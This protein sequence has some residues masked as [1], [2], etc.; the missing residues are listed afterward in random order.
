[1]KS[2]LISIKMSFGFGHPLQP[3]AIIILISFLGA[4]QNNF[5]EF[6]DQLSIEFLGNATEEF[7]KIVTTNFPEIPKKLSTNYSS[8]PMAVLRFK[9]GALNSRKSM[10]SPFL[11][12]LI[13]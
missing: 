5:K 3:K 12:R 7:V 1:M 10:V 2:D 8:L 9:A 4:F 11:P 13:S 6:N